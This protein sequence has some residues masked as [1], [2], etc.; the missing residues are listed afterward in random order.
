[1]Q[2]LLIIQFYAASA[3]NINAVEALGSLSLRQYIYVFTFRAI[4][5]LLEEIKIK[6]ARDSYPSQVTALAHGF[7]L[8]TS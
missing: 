3:I 8:A 5:L 6:L 4:L 1:M 2:I 7:S